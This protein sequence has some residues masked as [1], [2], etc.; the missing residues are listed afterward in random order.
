MFGDGFT[1]TVPG[2]L[3]GTFL[4]VDDLK[5]ARAELV[6]RGVDV[7]EPFHFDGGFLVAKGGG[8]TPGADPKGRSY[9]TFASF[10]DPDGNSWLLQEVTTR[11]PGRGLSSDAA[12]LTGLLQEAEQRHGTYEA[13]APKHHWSGWYAHYIA[14][15]ERGHTPYEAAADASFRIT[16]AQDQG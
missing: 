10:S 9:F 13:T 15:R 8:R 1:P 16:R 7:S 11:L 3:Q 4:V 5:T 14:Q 12:T 6:A 2:S